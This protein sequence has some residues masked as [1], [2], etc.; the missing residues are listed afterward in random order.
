MI[1]ND[2]SYEA[3]RKFLGTKY[4]NMFDF[5]LD[6][7]F[8]YKIEKK[9]MNLF[10]KNKYC[11]INVSM[12]QSKLKN[13]NVKKNKFNNLEEELS[14]LVIFVISKLKYDVVFAPHIYSD[15]KMI[16]KVLSKIN[17]F[18]I[19]KNISIL[20]Y[21]QGDLGANIIFNAYKN[22]DIV[23]AT[24]Y[25]SNVCSM[26]LG[27]KTIGIAS[28]DRINYLHKSLKSKNFVTIEDG[29]Y[30]KLKNKILEIKNLTNNTQITLKTIKNEKNKTLKKYHNFFKE[31]DLI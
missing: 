8:F 17:D 7:G 19:R 4:V 18:L 31:M 10:N 13:S 15:L 27:K 12:D 30:N 24:R 20:P 22:S 11:I 3:I 26:T 16:N 9:E 6:S 23:L 14:K 5:I 28:L 25:H 1:R 21:I 2:G 29:F